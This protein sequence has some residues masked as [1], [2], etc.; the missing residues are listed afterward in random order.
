AAQL[1][2]DLASQ[3]PGTSPLMVDTANGGYIHAPSMPHAGAAAVFRAGF[4]SAKATSGD[5]GVLSVNL[6][7]DRVRAAMSLIEGI[8][9]GQSLGALLGYQFELGLHDSYNL[10]E[11]DKF[12]YPLR[13]KFPLVANALAST[14]TTDP[15]ISIDAI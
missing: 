2:P 7:S 4:D 8:R 3:F 9:N 12:I 15:T 14:Q 6:S 1:P 11:V 13:L 10:A 5:A